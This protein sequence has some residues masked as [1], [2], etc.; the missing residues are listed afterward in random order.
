MAGFLSG[1]T[2]LQPICRTQ[3]SNGLEARAKTLP[4]FEGLMPKMTK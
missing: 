4:D 1:F 2:E 3:L